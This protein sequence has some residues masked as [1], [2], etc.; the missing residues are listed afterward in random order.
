M[1][2]IVELQT[3]VRTPDDDGGFTDLWV[4]VGT[5]WA[6]FAPPAAYNVE[7]VIGGAVTAVIDFVVRAYYHASATSRS[8]LIE[9]ATIYDVRGVRD[10][11]D[12]HQWMD[13]AVTERQ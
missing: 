10:I 3:P 4:T 13:L 8:R 7:K 9:G 6:E 12:R 1:R 5:F 11:E 2:R